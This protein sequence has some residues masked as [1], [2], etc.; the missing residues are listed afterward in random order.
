LVREGKL[1]NAMNEKTA[2]LNAE[3]QFFQKC[4]QELKRFS[5]Q[6]SQKI[7]AIDEQESQLKAE[8]VKIKARGECLL[9]NLKES[10]SLL[11]SC[12][13]ELGASNEHLNR[14]RAQEKV[15]ASIIDRTTL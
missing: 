1:K 15:V 9:D 5:E 8:Y 13:G 2:Q 6:L 11:S 4:I 12:V 14:I 10:E 7:V 3:V